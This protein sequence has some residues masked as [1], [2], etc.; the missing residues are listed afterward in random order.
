MPGVEDNLVNGW[1][2]EDKKSLLDL[3][4]GG[5]YSEA[6]DLPPLTEVVPKLWDKVK[7]AGVRQQD[8]L[9]KE[10]YPGSGVTGSDMMGMVI[11]SSGGIV[12]T[13]STASKLFRGWRDNLEQFMK[14]SSRRD[15]I[16]REAAKI[17]DTDDIKTTKHG[18]NIINKEFGLTGKVL[19]PEIKGAAGGK[20][21][22]AT[23]PR[24]NVISQKRTVE[25][26]K[27]IEQR[28]TAKKAKKEAK[29]GGEPRKTLVRKY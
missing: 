18:L 17:F 23:K 24:G 19:V 28:E 9:S 8:E 5:K 16:I 26:P 15:Y 2:A 6:K 7:E 22:Q 27:R 10:I 21:R 13:A 11:G 14:S 25:S 20:M 4:T 12:K 3:V 1:T 29:A